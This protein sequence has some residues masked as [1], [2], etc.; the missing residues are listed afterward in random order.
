[1]IPTPVSA[2]AP[3]SFHRN[4]GAPPSVSLDSA[5]DVTAVSAGGR[6]GVVGDVRV[7]RMDTVGSE[8]LGEA[9]FD[10]SQ[11]EIVSPRV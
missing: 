2:V 3:L 8:G 5:S 10:E 6:P 7:G 1:M 4:K 9:S 11:F